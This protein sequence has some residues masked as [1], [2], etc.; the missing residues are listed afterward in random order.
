MYNGIP[1]EEELKKIKTEIYREWEKQSEI[2]GN[3]MLLAS[4]IIE[5]EISALKGKPKI[6]KIDCDNTNCENCVNHNACDYEYE[7]KGSE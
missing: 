1:L 4:E 7:L 5:N 3:G 6:E 2:I